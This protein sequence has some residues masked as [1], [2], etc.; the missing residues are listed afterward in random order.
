MNVYHSGGFFGMILV[1]S[2]LN[3]RGQGTPDERYIPKLK[4]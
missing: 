2:M 4:T 3:I 1:L